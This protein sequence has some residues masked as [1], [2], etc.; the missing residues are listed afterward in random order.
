MKLII[1]LLAFFPVLAFSQSMD[2][3]AV[4]EGY[5]SYENRIIDLSN[6]NLS[7]IPPRAINFEVEVLILD[8]NN[9]T[10]LP[11]WFVNLSN[12]RSLSVRN[13]KLKDVD[14]LMFC[15]NLEELYLTHNPNLYVLPS[16]SRCKKLCVIDVVDTKINF[17][18]INIRSM[19]NL[20]YFK[21]S[22][23]K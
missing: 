21:Y 17:L 3:I 2:S 10:E 20:G 8:N 14:I 1:L 19:E 11:S 18:P 5:G 12:L 16:L 22:I 7:E 4:Y 13:N 15:E 9:L 23:K 6:R